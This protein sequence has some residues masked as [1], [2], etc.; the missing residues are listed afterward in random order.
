MD[1]FEVREPHDSHEPRLIF[2]EEGLSYSIGGATAATGGR[3]NDCKDT[4]LRA[5]E[6][7]E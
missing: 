7:Y 4:V 6:K 2:K 3:Y 5:S 1:K